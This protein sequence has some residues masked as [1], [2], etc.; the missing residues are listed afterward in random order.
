MVD[1]NRI[2]PSLS[3]ILFISFFYFIKLDFFFITIITLFI[4]YD[5]A[6]SKIL[7]FYFS[8]LFFFILL[9]S[10]SIY[11]IGNYNFFNEALIIF[12]LSIF[13]LIFCKKFNKIIFSITLFSILFLSYNI[14]LEDRSYIFY[15]IILSF[16]NDTIAFFSGKFFKG[17]LIIPKLSPKKTWSGTSVSSLLTF[18]IMIYFQYNILFSILVSISFFLG[19]IFFSLFKR[20]LKI[21]DFSNLLNGHGGILD[22]F[23]SIFF[24]I[25]LFNVYLFKIL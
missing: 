22:R 23:D 2:I 19:D 20:R 8:I 1:K 9:S 13:F 17:P 16:I 25:F 5:L 21:K 10:L 15:I 4:S 14:I 6:K 24:P 11:H 18:F 12:I 3:I 7:N